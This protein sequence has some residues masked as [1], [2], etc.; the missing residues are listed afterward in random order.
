MT[1]FNLPFFPKNANQTSENSPWFRDGW[2]WRLFAI[3]NPYNAPKHRFLEGDE[4]DIALLRTFSSELALRS[5]RLCASIKPTSIQRFL[6]RLISRLQQPFSENPILLSHVRAFS[7]QVKRHDMPHG[8]ASF[9]KLFH[10][11]RSRNEGF[12]AR[13]HCLKEEVVLRMASNSGMPLPSSLTE[14]A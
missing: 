13:R 1:S 2:H 12:W 6:K 5:P 8:H 10:L 14:S 9:L 11:G 3:C 4:Y 7:R